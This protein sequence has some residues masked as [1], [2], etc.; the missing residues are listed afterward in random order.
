MNTSEHR[1]YLPYTFAIA[2]LGQAALALSL[3]R[4]LSS[5][6][7]YQWLILASLTVLTG[8]FT[9]KIPGV[10]SKISVADIF[11][12]ANLYLFGTAAGTI[13]AALDGFMGSLHFEKA[14][15]LEYTLFNIGTMS[16]SAFLAGAVFF[17]ML[18]RGPLYLGHTAS[19]GELLFPAAVSA[20]LYYLTNSASVA[21]IVGL[22]LGRN[23]FQV[24]RENFL[25]AS[26]SYLVSAFITLL[27]VYQVGS[28]TPLFLGVIVAT[29]LI[30]YFAY[31]AYLVRGAGDQ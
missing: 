1:R 23:I 3:Y 15:K 10:N 16:L 30:T 19:L 21:I 25:W 28:I 27:V 7:S 4:E 6:I 9:V 12:F 22:E 18:G 8:S 24:W 11:A 13:T 31:K 14:R 20:L 29:L 2:A 17:R 26:P 5:S